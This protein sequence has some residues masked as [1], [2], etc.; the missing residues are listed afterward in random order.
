M[1][2]KKEA[3][4]NCV[5]A[6]NDLRNQNNLTLAALHSLITTSDSVRSKYLEERLSMALTPFNHT[7]EGDVCDIWLSFNPDFNK[8]KK[9][10]DRNQV[11]VKKELKE[12]LTD[13]INLEGNSK[14]KIRLKSILEA[15]TKLD[16]L[17]YTNDQG[18]G[19]EVKVTRRGSRDFPL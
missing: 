11:K 3:N 17:C 12:R 2:N 14:A 19:L 18:I 13:E 5:K 9:A 15:R 4:A 10:L 16:Y 1:F 6:A 7:G 8:F